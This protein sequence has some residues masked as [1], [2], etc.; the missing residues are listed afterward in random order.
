MKKYGLLITVFIVV[1]VYSTPAQYQGCGPNPLPAA[2]SAQQQ[3][4]GQQSQGQIQAKQIATIQAQSDFNINTQKLQ[5]AFRIQQIQNVGNPTAMQAA[6]QSFQTAM[7]SLNAAF[8]QQI[9][10]IQGQ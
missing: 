8:Q 7:Q 9:R 4:V 3:Y 5:T 6:T 2:Q 1:A 10:S